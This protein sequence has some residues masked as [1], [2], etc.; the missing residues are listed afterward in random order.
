MS[1]KKTAIA[2]F[3]N[4]PPLYTRV[5][6][7]LKGLRKNGVE[8]H[9]CS[10]DYPWRWLRLI[11]LTFK[12]LKIAKKVNALMVSE[13]GQAYVPLAKI[14]AVLTKK[15]LLFDAFL[16]Y[17]HVL[18]IDTKM[19]KPQSLKGRYFFYLDKLSCKLADLV[20]LDTEEHI[21]YFCQTFTLPHSKFLSLP[22]GSDDEWF[23]P[24]VKKSNQGSSSFIVFLVASFYPLH[25]IEHVV[26]AAK[27]LEEYPDIKFIIAGN[28]PTRKT[29]E[30]LIKSLSSKNIKLQDFVPPYE[31]PY[32]MREADVCLGQFGNTEHT[33]LVVPA[34]VYDALAM[35]KPVI[36]GN[37]NAVRKVL[38]DKENVILCPVADPQAL[39]ESILLL[40]N[41][42]Q[43]REK[44][45][46]NS[47]LFFRENFPLVKTGAQLKS[48]IQN[49]IKN[50]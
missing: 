3:G 31:L 29:I 26:Q 2:Y 1:N 41:N 25:G 30:Q 9:E 5:R 23:Y 33:Q 17:Y 40:K 42:A 36:T 7:T 28:G 13:G 48:I 18:V 19:V 32:L 45:A 44:I 37:T 8:I 20:L 15:P 27:I 16:S 21:N 34:K 14:L 39:A 47:Y 35:Q 4:Y 46:K 43:L 50:Y 12:Y 6:T 11:I 22:V 24:M 38:T 10:S 49:L